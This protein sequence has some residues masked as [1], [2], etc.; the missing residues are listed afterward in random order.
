LL[1]VAAA[2]IALGC[3]VQRE[4]PIDTTTA[5][6]YYQRGRA[7]LEAANYTVAIE[8]FRALQGSF[9]FS[10]ATR[11]ARLDLIYAYYKSGQSEEAIAAAEAFEREHPTHPR[12][13]YSLYMR[14]L[15][16]FDDDANFLERLFKVDLSQRPP[17]DSLNAFTVLEELIRRFPESQYVADARQRMV[18]LRNRLAAYENHVARYYIERGAFIAAARRAEFA[19]ENYPGAPELEESLQLLVTAYERVGM[20]D[21]AADARRVLRE[22]YGVDASSTAR[23]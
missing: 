16:Y 1:L 14:G 20:G 11:Q 6:P 7:S 12:V 21:L 17:K 3:V 13:D 4:A 10:N 8:I 18:F 22:N 5:D 9:P 2:S 19:I 23:L 15:I